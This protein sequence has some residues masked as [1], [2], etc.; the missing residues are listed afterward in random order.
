MRMPSLHDQTNEFSYCLSEHQKH[1]S[2]FSFTMMSQPPP[3]VFFPK[4]VNWFQQLLKQKGN[5]I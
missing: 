2:E 3:S 5:P 1:I 4:Q